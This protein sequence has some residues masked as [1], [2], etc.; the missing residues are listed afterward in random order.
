VPVPVA[1]SRQPREL[2]IV[3]G[4]APLPWRPIKL[5]SLLW[6]SPVARAVTVGL[7]VF[8]IRAFKSARG[9]EG[10]AAFASI[11]SEASIMWSESA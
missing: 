1:P 9:A 5:A 4:G 8:G 7:I 11:A 2:D 3:V 6:P 10:L